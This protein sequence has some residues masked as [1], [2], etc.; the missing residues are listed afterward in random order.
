[1]DH[2]QFLL[3]KANNGGEEDVSGHALMASC[4]PESH[5][6]NHPDQPY[7][8]QM[9]QDVGMSDLIKLLDLSN[10]LPLD[11]EITPVMAWAGILVHPQFGELSGQDFKQMKEDLVGK[12]RC[13]G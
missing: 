12:V 11:G 13:Y 1:M 6:H 3:V 9:P 2:M 4:P 8:S 10:R 5:I 7:P